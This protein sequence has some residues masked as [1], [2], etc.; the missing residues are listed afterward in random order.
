MNATIK[1]LIYLLVVIVLTSC[2]ENDTSA[3]S[4][5]NQAEQVL[6]DGSYEC[7]ASNTTQG[8]GPYNLECEKIGNELTI[9]FSNG[10]YIVNDIDSINSNGEKS[11]TLDTTHPEEGDNWDVVINE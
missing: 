7:E 8:N 3:P 5:D 10:G 4:S 6:A 2:G 1:I 9:H 11:W